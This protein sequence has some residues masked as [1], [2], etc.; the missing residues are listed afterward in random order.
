MTAKQAV[1]LAYTYR[2]L[3]QRHGHLLHLD[4]TQ[5]TKG[6]HSEFWYGDCGIRYANVLDYIGGAQQPRISQVPASG[7]RRT[8]RSAMTAGCRRRAGWRSCGCWNL[9]L[10]SSEAEVAGWAPAQ[11]RRFQTL[12]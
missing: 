3:I 6:L 8:P 5:P 10:R 11:T 7:Q 2:V 12:R 9:S 4:V 1:T